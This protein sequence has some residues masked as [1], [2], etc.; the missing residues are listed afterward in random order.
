VFDL[1]LTGPDQ[2]EGATY[3]AVGPDADP[4]Q[5]KQ[6]GAYVYQSVA[7]NIFIGLRVLDPDPD[8]F[9][10][11]RSEY[12]PPRIRTAISSWATGRVS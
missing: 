11:F 3:I 6:D 7:N 1:G 12:R 8:Y 2:G 4:E 10:R 9:D 5:Y